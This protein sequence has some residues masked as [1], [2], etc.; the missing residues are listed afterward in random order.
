MTIDKVRVRHSTFDTGSKTVQLV[1]R[2]GR[3]DG[4]ILGVA[5]VTRVID[6]VDSESV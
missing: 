3:Y 4:P 2:L 6:A 1:A 5:S